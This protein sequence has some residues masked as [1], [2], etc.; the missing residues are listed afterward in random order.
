MDCNVRGT[1]VGPWW[2]FMFESHLT[3][4][5]DSRAR[6][7]LRGTWW[8]FF[9]PKKGIKKKKGE[10]WDGGAPRSP[11]GSPPSATCDQALTTG[12][13]LLTRLPHAVR[14]QGAPGDLSRHAAGPEGQWSR[15]LEAVT[16]EP[17]D[18]RLRRLALVEATPPPPAKRQPK[19]GKARDV[20]Q[21][22][23]E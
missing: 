14:L 13:D 17:V 15:L 22:A 1:L 16:S 21:E 19:R 12:C 2:G 10:P 18:H 9:T 4:G 3:D 23:A 7:D 5:H 8:T 20:E 11:S 6:I